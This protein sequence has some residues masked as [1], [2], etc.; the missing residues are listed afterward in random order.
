MDDDAHVYTPNDGCVR[1]CMRVCAVFPLLYHC[2]S[3]QLH[4]DTV[5]AIMFYPRS[6]QNM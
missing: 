5:Y 1:V 2:G 3:R 6:T 4:L